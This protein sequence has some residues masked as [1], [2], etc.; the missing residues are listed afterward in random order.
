MNDEL[1]AEFDKKGYVFLGW[2]DVGFA[3]VLNTPVEKPED[4]KKVKMWA[5][6]SDPIA[7]VI[8]SGAVKSRSPGRALMLFSLQTGAINAF[9]TSP[10]WPVSPPAGSP[11]PSTWVPRRSL[12]VSNFR[13]SRRRLG[14]APPEEQDILKKASLKWHDKLVKKVRKDNKKSLKV[15]EKQGIKLVKVSDAQSAE[16]DTLA[17]KVQD[18]L[19]GKVYTREILNT[20][21]KHL[22]A[23]R[24]R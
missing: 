12:W 13:W 3:Y 8:I 7:S 10:E 14:Q 18:K 9:T 16:W 17:I 19:A 5:W 20:V 22:K 15:L 24:S 6:S 23:F 21:R 2:G 1:T 11:R 4:L